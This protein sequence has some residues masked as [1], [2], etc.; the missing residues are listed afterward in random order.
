MLR[1]CAVNRTELRTWFAPDNSIFT[2][3]RENKSTEKSKKLLLKKRSS[4]TVSNLHARLF[5]SAS[6][7][8]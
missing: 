2:E 8:R 1:R 7:F 6:R 4:F 5:L 3:D